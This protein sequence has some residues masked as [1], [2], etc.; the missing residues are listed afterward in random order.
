MELSHSRA[1]HVFEQL[2]RAK[3]HIKSVRE[4]AEATMGHAKTLVEVGGGSALA[5]YLNVRQGLSGQPWQLFGHDAD[6]VIGFIGGGAAIAGVAGKYDEDVLAVSAGFLA[7]WANRQG[8]AA[9]TKAMATQASG[10]IAASQMAGAIPAGQ[11]AGAVPAGQYAGAV[12][13]GA[14]R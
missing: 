10:F 7:S 1:R 2:Q 12:P 5:G 3:A 13:A 4:K 11:Y 6:M 14:Y 9:A 8:A